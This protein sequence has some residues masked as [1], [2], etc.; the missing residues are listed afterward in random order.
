[1]AASMIDVPNEVLVNILNNLGQADLKATR[2]V[3]QLWSMFGVLKLFERIYVSCR[4]K[5]L[6]VFRLVSSHSLYRQAVKRLVYDT[7]TTEEEIT[8]DKRKYRNSLITQ[9]YDYRKCPDKFGK[10]RVGTFPAKVL[11]E[12]QCLREKND[13]LEFTKHFT[14]DDSEQ[15]REVL[16]GFNAYYIL[17]DQEQDVLCSGKLLAT[18]VRGVKDLPNLQEVIV[19]GAAPYDESPFRRS[20][21]LTYLFPGDCKTLVD[22]KKTYDLDKVYNNGYNLLLRALSTSGKRLR[23]FRIDDRGDYGIPLQFFDKNFIGR[24]TTSCMLKT[25]SGLKSLSLAIDPTLYEASDLRKQPEWVSLHMPQLTHLSLTTRQEDCSLDTE[26][27]PTIPF[28]LIQQWSYPQLRHLSLSGIN[29][30]KYQLIEVMKTPCL[31]YLKLGTLELNG[32]SWTSALDAMQSCAPKPKYVFFN[33]QLQYPERLRRGNFYWENL[34]SRLGVDEDTLPHEIEM[35]INF[36]GVN[37]LLPN[38][39]C[40]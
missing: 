8:K 17:A 29:I 30:S 26:G 12:S 10:F 20:W 33:G 18:I 39:R 27:R 35:Y 23:E 15:L 31:T 24:M 40:S 3:C 9:L 11:A 4:L 5:D 2:L 14:Q 34:C 25:Y 32:K 7:S 21:P 19:C 6:E 16:D 22:D 38:G 28:G 36:G 1:M 37:P 13:H